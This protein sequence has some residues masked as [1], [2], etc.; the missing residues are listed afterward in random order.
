MKRWLWCLALLGA[1]LVPTTAWAQDGD[2]GVEADVNSRYI[3]RGMP[4]SEGPVLQPYA[5]F[6]HAGTVASVWSNLEMGSGARPWEPDQLFFT[7]T[8]EYAQRGWRVEPTFQGYTWRGAP[9]EANASTLELSAKASH[10][11][12][13]VTL[14]TVHTLDIASYLGAYVVDAGVARADAVQAWKIESNALLTW[15][16]GPFNRN[17]IGT[18]GGSLNNVQLTVAGLRTSSRRWYVRPHAELV[19]TLDGDVADLLGRRLRANA[20]IAV[21]REF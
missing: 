7:L 9:G 5:W 20:G 6:T 14:V 13:A 16:N 11:V 21:G 1:C 3:W 18:S 17:Y 19:W 4:Y 15:A 10:P 8:R 12:G 2:R